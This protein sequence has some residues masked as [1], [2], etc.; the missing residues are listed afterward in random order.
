MNRVNIGLIGCGGMGTSL[1]KTSGNLEVASTVAVCDLDEERAKALGD[2]LGVPYVTD[3][4]K[5]LEQDDVDAVIVATPGFMHHNQVMD[6]AKAGK[7]I[8]CEKPMALTV[9]DCD[10]MIDV[11][12]KAGVK[13]MVGQVLRYLP[14]FEK[15]KEIID[16]GVIGDPFSIYSWRVGGGWGNLGTHW[17]SRKD[18]CGGTLFEVSV[19]E[20]D[21]MRYIMGDASRVAS[22]SGTFREKGIDYEDT[23]HILIRFKNGGIGTHIAGQ[24]SSLGGYDGKILCTKGSL[25]FNN[26][27]SSVHYKSFDGEEVKIGDEGL[28][29]YEP[30]V[31]KELR[32]FL[33]AIIK[34]T[35]PAIPGEDGRKA[36]ELAQ[37][38]YLSAE[39]ERE[40]VLPLS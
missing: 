26:W 39:E 40:V 15:I 25:Y 5:L 20:L 1:V 38:A 17:R 18:L 31:Q 8:F 24:S 27:P 33:E 7:H 21:F 32:L 29:G 16:S 35:A 34:D 11:A 9:S 13:L 2:E 23:I 30:A 37:A 19:H 22:F 36:V 10:E 3:H 4:H 6:A 12:A 28:G 14:V